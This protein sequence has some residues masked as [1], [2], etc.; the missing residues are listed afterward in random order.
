MAA[1]QYH[2]AVCVAAGL[3]IPAAQQKSFDQQRLICTLNK[4]DSVTAV[5][6]LTTVFF[7]AIIQRQ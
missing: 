4:M 2:D 1:F 6:Y 5:S 3:A 7:A